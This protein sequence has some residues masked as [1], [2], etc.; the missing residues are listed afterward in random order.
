[1]TINYIAMMPCQT[2]WLTGGTAYCQKLFDVLGTNS[3][4]YIKQTNSFIE[5]IRRMFE[6]VGY[7]KKQLK[8]NHLNVVLFDSASLFLMIP[9]FLYCMV[10]R[11]KM[12]PIHHHMPQRS[13]LQK[14]LFKFLLL[15]SKQLLV[16]SQFAF[17]QLNKPSFPHILIN[18]TLKYSGVMEAVP[19]ILTDKP[20]FNL[21][22]IGSVIQRKNLLYMLSI[23]KL[24][25]DTIRL[26]VCGPTEFD[27]DYYKKCRDF[28]IQNNLE[29]QVDFLG[30]VDEDVLEGL[31]KNSDLFIFLSSYEG[32]GMV[33][34]EAMSF[35]LPIILSDIPPHRDI[36]DNGNYGHLVGLD[37]PDD[38]AQKILMLSNDKA[39]YNKSSALAIERAKTYVW[40]HDVVCEKV[41]GFLVNE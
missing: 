9:M 24:L 28:V 18:P 31:Y 14:S 15:F 8:K 7:I 5:K 38:I 33:N 19:K 22:Y 26:Q 20:V 36:V 32:F 30:K 6:L 13:F 27:A 34:I 39:A 35:G 1:M 11:V 37:C 4:F 17:D 10:F 41:S 25:P 23:I 16:S 3:V 21:L 12:L 2:E 40:Q 29:K